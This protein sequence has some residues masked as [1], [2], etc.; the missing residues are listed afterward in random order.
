MTRPDVSVIIA[1]WKA[2]HFLERAVAS[3]L[4]SSGVRVEVVIVDDASPDR[5]M[6]VAQRLAAADGRVITSRLDSNAG[7]SAARNR[8]IALA[9]G[10]YIAILDADDVMVPERLSR[11]VHHAETTGADLVADN[12]FEVDD[13]GA[14]ISE[15]CFLLSPDFAQDRNIDLQTWV[16]YNEPMKRGDCIGYLKPVMRRE[17]LPLSGTV[18]D[19]ALR[20]SEDYYLIAGLLAQGRKMGYVAQPGYFYTRSAGS[21]S[22]RLKPEHTQAWLDAERR[23]ADE[24]WATLSASEKRSISLRKRKL[25]NV[26]QLVATTEAMKSRRLGNALAM[27]VSD[28]RGS[29]YTLGVLGRIALG[30]MLGRKL[31]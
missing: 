5:T 14:R 21:T 12:M 9:S 2:E 7:P 4:A 28:L 10:R 16:A 18:Y 24:Y 8:A 22:H 26:H 1:A 15:G 27:L 13:S 20:N 31:V 3:A 19:T 6:T 29:A 25:R 11:L 17:A 23:F 30:K